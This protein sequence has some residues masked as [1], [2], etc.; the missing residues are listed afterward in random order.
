MVKMEAAEISKDKNWAIWNENPSWA[1]DASS[2]AAAVHF[3][4][5]TGHDYLRSHLYRNSITDSLDCTLCNS[6]QPMTAEHSDVHPAVKV[7]I[8]LSKI[9]RAHAL[10]SKVLL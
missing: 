4:L 6:G 9:L 8:I 5:L 1:P 2:K 7:L 10:M 3:R